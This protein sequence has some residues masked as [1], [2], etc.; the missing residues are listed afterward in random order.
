MSITPPKPEPPEASQGKE[1]PGT[2]LWNAQA[3]Q[4]ALGLS[5]SPHKQA[6][7]LNPLAP[8]PLERKLELSR[9]Q[10]DKEHRE[11]GK[12]WKDSPQGRVA[13]RFFSRAGMGAFGYALGSWYFTRRM[14]GYT[15]HGEVGNE[16]QAIARGFDKMVFDP[17]KHAVNALGFDGK[18]FTT[19]RPTAMFEGY[20]ELGRS[21][22]HDVALVTGD[23]FTMSVFDY[24]GRC[25]A[26]MFD[27]N[28]KVEW[29]NDDGTVNYKKATTHFGK[30]WWNAITF[31]GGE[32]WAVAALY[33]LLMRHVGTPLV[34]KFS[35]AYQHAF[36]HGDSSGGI[37]LGKNG[38]VKGN[39]IGAAVFNIWERFTTYNVG[40]LL[41]REAYTEIGDRLTNWQKGK[42]SDPFIVSAT[43]QDTP[44]ETTQKGI[45]EF[46]SWLARSAVKGTMYMLPAVPFFW[47]TRAPQHSYVS[48]FSKPGEGVLMY[49]ANKVLRANS[50]LADAANFSHLTP[51]YYSLS[52]RLGINPFTPEGFNYKTVKTDALGAALRPFGNFSDAARNALAAP[53]ETLFKPLFGND[54][55]SL[56]NSY[57]LASISYFPYFAAK[58]DIL[59]KAWDTGRTDVAVERMNSG[60]WHLD[61]REARAG[62][63][64]IWQSISAGK[65]A[66][67]ERER[68]AQ[69]RIEKDLSP[70]DSSYE[71][72]SRKPGAQCNVSSA[73]RLRDMPSPSASVH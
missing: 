50:H 10:W 48:V 31:A 34:S 51:V 60:L 24:W 58:S 61:G 19:F 72:I 63:K 29:V 46:G 15:P 40:T 32:D 68:E 56:A 4:V 65:L 37:I 44:L 62:A 17:L 1:Q 41:F 52:R 26:D 64:E 9:E 13:I 7:P 35:P 21:G 39:N 71:F 27:P 23:F 22:G 38:L 66:D 69:C 33:V 42:P 47:I 25:I 28:V 36:D 11:H 5:P 18:A 2:A 73:S 20:K 49:G 8:T 67:P 70:S 45:G 14:K 43:A 59:S 55:N 6:D 12:R 53:I 30:N 57:I 16:V 3:G 54:A